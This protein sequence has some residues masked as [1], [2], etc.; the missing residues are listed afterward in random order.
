MPAESLAGASG[1]PLTPPISC[2]S[3]ADENALT[4]IGI[5][6]YLS[7]GLHI[8][9]GW[10]DQQ[11]RSRAF[12][13]E[14]QRVL[15][16]QPIRKPESSWPQ[17]KVCKAWNTGVLQ[18]V[19]L[20][21][22]FFFHCCLCDLVFIF[23]LYFRPLQPCMGASFHMNQETYPNWGPVFVLLECG[24]C[25]IFPVKSRTLKV[26]LYNP[27]TRLVNYTGSLLLL[28]TLLAHY[29]MAVCSR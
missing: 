23:Y 12:N 1:L 18:L 17:Q 15:A 27:V 5:S 14:K 3:A 11:K 13:E 7:A 24:G 22:G 4:P 9:Q 19:D 6:D 29:L 2:C 16:M 26:I 8:R 28:R 25:I 21:G 10:L 20:I